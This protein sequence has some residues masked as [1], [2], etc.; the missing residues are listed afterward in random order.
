VSATTPD[1]TIDG[2]IIELFAFP[3][4]SQTEIIVFG[5][6]ARD[7]RRQSLGHECDITCSRC[8]SDLLYVL[9]SRPVSDDTWEIEVRCPDCDWHETIVLGRY[10][11]ERFINQL[12]RQKRALVRDLGQLDAA[13]FRED[14]ERELALVRD[15][16]ILPADF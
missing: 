10:V 12:H 7:L 8:G 14:V 2:I 3:D 5:K 11:T 1:E 9:S 15:D 4:G 16:L 13:R 6:A